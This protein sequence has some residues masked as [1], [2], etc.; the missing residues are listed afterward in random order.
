MTVTHLTPADYTTSRWSGGATTELL[1][2]PRGAVYSQRD[3][4]FRVSS[5]TVE[6]PESTFTA[7]PDYDRLIATLEGEIDL[8]HDGG[9]PIHL[10]PYEVHAF[11]GGSATRSFGRCR[12]FNLMLRKGRAAGSLVPLTAGTDPQRVPLT[13]E[14]ST[15][16]LYCAK[17]SCTVGTPDGAYD[18]SCGESLL[19][20]DVQAQAIILQGSARLMLARMREMP[21]SGSARPR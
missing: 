15:A 18:L 1:V 12:D 14:D 10:R 6:L 2:R 9:A 20:E 17:G 21:E 4:L 3:F 19:L 16:L 11:D 7:L 13:G 5:A 8:V